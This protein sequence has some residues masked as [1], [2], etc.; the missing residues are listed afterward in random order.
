MLKRLITL[1]LLSCCLLCGCHQDTVTGNGHNSTIERDINKFSAINVSGQFDINL[2][3]AKSNKLQLS[4]DDNLAAYIL[5]EVKNNTLF[6]KPKDNLRLKSNDPIVINVPF[7][8]LTAIHISGANILNVTGIDSNSLIVSSS[9]QAQLHMI[10]K[11]AKL[12]LFSAGQSTLDAQ[13]LVAKQANIKTAGQSQIKVHAD[14]KLVLMVSGQAKV[15]YY[16]FP[17]TIL[18]QV[19]GQGEI[20][21]KR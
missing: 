5:T 21:A 7:Q 3:P 2:T 12:L 9:G 6:I 4:A 17:K 20:S 14:D 8:Q 16:G 18:Q 13:D 1:C 15:D 10:G 11:V 19:F